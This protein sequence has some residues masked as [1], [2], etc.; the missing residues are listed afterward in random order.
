M[1]A[2]DLST[3]RWRKSNRSSDKANCVE[4]AVTGRAVAVRDSKD[5]AGGAL[6]VSPLVWAAFTSA[7]GD[8]ELS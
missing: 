8:G 5:P 4:V 6:V 2:P 7:L 3:A 1:P